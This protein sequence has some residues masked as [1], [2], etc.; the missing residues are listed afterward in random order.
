MNSL[1]PS[2]AASAQPWHD[3]RFLKACRREP[4][5]ITPVW[6][7]RQAGRYMKDYRELRSRVGFLELC[8]DPGLVSEVTVRAAERLGVD[9][10]II[11][12]DLL[13]IVE[14]LGLDLAYGKGEGPDIRPVVR[15]AA[16]VDR[17][18][19]VD[20]EES[21]AY[22]LAGIRQTRSDLDSRL[23]LLGFAG[24]PFTVASYLIEGGGSKTY[25]HTKS[26]MYNDPGAWRALMELLAR[27]LAR[28]ANAQIAAGVQA[29]QIFDTWIGCLSPSD[30]QEFVQPYSRLLI[31]SITPGTPVIHFGTG[32]GM[33]LEAMRDAGGSVIGL[34]FRV[35][36]DQAWARLGS[37][38]AVQGNL[39]PVVLCS[40]PALIRRQVE[41]ILGQAG[42]R[43]GHIFNL[44]HGI[45][46]ETPYDHVV[47]LVKMVHELSAPALLGSEAAKRVS[48]SFKP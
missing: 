19:E 17:L 44:G 33:L 43:P 42:G 24:A 32:T 28:Y 31:E 6:L 39:D 36:L 22:L 5:D 25:R 34:D 23:P 14:P 20:P 45:L 40:E 10:A 26:L 30:Y 4:V 16:D 47:E 13:L 35:E 38:V 8:K 2:P 48:P 12:A 21:L 9:A 18:R 37:Q 15:H 29:V 41:K 27:N 11:F 7:M 46:P 1:E 3:S